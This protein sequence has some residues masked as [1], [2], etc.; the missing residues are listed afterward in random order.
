MRATTAR[1]PSSIFSQAGHAQATGRLGAACVARRTGRPANP[2]PRPV[3]RTQRLRGVRLLVVEDNALNRQRRR[4]AVEQRGRLGGPRRR[5]AGGRSAGAGGERAVR[6][7]ADGHADAGYRWSRGDR[8]IRADG[9]FAGLPIL[10]MTANARWPTAK[11][12]GGGHE[13]PCGEA[14]RQGAPGALPARSSRQERRRGRAGN[15]SGRGRTGRGAGRYRR[16]FRRQP[17]A[18]RPGVAAL[19]SGHAGPLRPARTP[20]RRGR[21]PGQRRDPAYHQGQRFHRWR[22]RLAGRAS[23]LE[24]ALRRADPLRGMEILRRHPPRRTAHPVRCLR[25]LACRRCSAT[26]RRSRRA[27]PRRGGQSRQGFRRTRGS[28]ASA[29]A[30]RANNAWALSADTPEARPGLERHP[31]PCRSVPSRRRAAGRG[32]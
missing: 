30:C 18:D 1:R 28:P 17:G 6:R 27:E 25:L 13:R 8:R 21:C 12:A 14:D 31:F 29:A 16:A 23:E 11:P 9:R 10:A 7:G 5:R 4:R 24:Q 19:R 15:G 32:R 22:Q 20:A 2:P 3:E 26:C